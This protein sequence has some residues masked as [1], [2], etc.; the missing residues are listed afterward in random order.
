VSTISAQDVR[1]FVLGRLTDPLQAVGLTPDEVPDNFDLLNSGVIDSLGILEIVAALEERF[2]FEVDFE[3]L[4]PE[5]LTI[6][7]PLSAFVAAQ[8]NNR[9]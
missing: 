1:L 3:E 7:G 8:R 9:S 4:D 5:N 6:I 2:D